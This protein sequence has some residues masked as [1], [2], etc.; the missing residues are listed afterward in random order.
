MTCYGYTLQPICEPLE[1][2]NETTDSTSSLTNV[3]EVSI[4]VDYTEFVDL[5]TLLLQLS[6]Y[7]ESYCSSELTVSIL[8]LQVVHNAE[9]VVEVQEDFNIYVAP[10]DNGAGNTEQSHEVLCG[11]ASRLWETMQ[12]RTSG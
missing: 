2:N 3:T 4:I 9:V 1:I 10:M 7:P 12:I 6:D 11:V 8:Q 5:Y